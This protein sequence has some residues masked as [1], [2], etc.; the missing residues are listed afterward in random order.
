MASNFYPDPTPETTTFD[1]WA[2]RYDD[3]ADNTWDEIHDNAGNGA[4][5]DGSGITNLLHG[6]TANNL[7]IN[8]IRCIY[9][10]DT[11]AI[12][13]SDT[14]SAATLSIYGS[15][16]DDSSW[17][18][19]D[20]SANIY[21]VT[22]SSTVTIATSDYNLANWSSVAGCDTSIDATAWAAGAPGYFDFELNATGLALLSKTGVS[23]LGMREATFD[24]PDIDCTTQA[25][26]ER[27]GLQ[28]YFS[29]QA[30]FTNDPKLVVTH[31]SSV[32]FPDPNAEDTCVDGH[33]FYDTA[34]ANF[35]TMR[36]ATA[37]I[38]NDSNTT[39][40]SAILAFASG[41]NFTDMGVGV[42]TFDTSSIPD[43]DTIDSATYSLWPTTDQDD[44][45]GTFY[46]AGKNSGIWPS[47]ATAVSA[48]D[49]QLAITK[50]DAS[51]FTSVAS[52]AF[53]G[54]GTGAY[55]DMALDDLTTISKTGVSEFCTVDNYTYTNTSS[56][57]G[58]SQTIQVIA[59]SADQGGTANDPKLVVVHSGAA[60][61]EVSVSHLLTLT[62]VGL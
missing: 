1:G 51:D 47:V 25:G 45:T 10:F 13:D 53:G 33:S 32:F 39:F 43:D 30:G 35:A 20:I 56:T 44:F 11:S 57:F 36:G 37:N 58:S 61:G 27:Q 6:Y 23:K 26:A 41:S 18:N 48:A 14:I 28:G 17:N 55:K 7:Y 40:Q 38:V 60:S 16:V 29:E 52:V 22:P 59:Y 62:G 19:A 46:V 31:D 15:G 42:T 54:L 9:L 3:P 4:A 50:F 21:Q 12:P 5:D 2:R 8:L 49:Y 34:G 24:A